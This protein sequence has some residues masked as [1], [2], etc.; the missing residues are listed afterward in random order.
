MHIP[1]TLYPVYNATMLYATR[2][3]QYASCFIHGKASGEQIIIQSLNPIPTAVTQGRM[4][5][6]YNKNAYQLFLEKK[7]S[8]CV[9]LISESKMAAA[10]A[11]VTYKIAPVAGCK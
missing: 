3:L 8:L 6:K 10:H 2:Y 4:I 9:F 1:H 11:T 7:F 5:T